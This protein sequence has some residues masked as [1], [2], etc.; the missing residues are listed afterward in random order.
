[1]TN[2][3]TGAHRAPDATPGEGASFP[4]TDLLLCCHVCR[5]EFRAPKKLIGKRLP[6][7]HC[8]ALVDVT[9]G[10]GAAA[11]PLAGKKIGNCRLTYRLGAGGI[12]LVYAADQLSV[13]RRVAI[14]MLGAKAG[15]NQVL[16]SRFQRESQL[17]AQI[18]HPNVVHV[19]DCGFD[20]GVHFQIM[21]LV[22]GGTLAGLIEERGRLPWREACDLALQLS[23]AL[24]LMHR[25]DI[26]HRDIKP[27]NILIGKDAQGRRIAKLA[28]LGLAKQID[29]ASAGNGLTMEGKPLGSPSF[30]PPEQVE[31]AKHATRRSDIYGL[32]ASL[33]MSVTGSRPFEGKTPY[34]VMSRVLTATL[35]PPIS[36]VADLPQPLNELIMRLL[37][38][39]PDGRPESMGDLSKLLE[40]ILTQHA[41]GVPPRA[42]G[43]AGWKRSAPPSAVAAPSADERT[44]PTLQ[45]AT[46][47]R[48]RPA[49]AS[50]W[51]RPG[52]AAQPPAP[53]VASAQLPADARSASSAPPRPEARSWPVAAV[54]V[55]AV[56]IVCMLILVL[57]R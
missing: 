47:P 21:E 11:D 53:A 27:A 7:A 23:Q 33:Y 39:D 13:G 48:T 12:G 41:D 51:K 28:D 29:G 17:A 49:T 24:E 5:H 31:D 37:S 43:T 36:L 8:G 56:V 9:S 22:D 52:S 34:E 25:M 1:M 32:G 26:I 57:I 20:R 3:P 40:A 4:A 30:M 50:T 55:M 14:K 45:P 2:I 42:N 19:Y 38:R 46:G 44:P 15:A 16:V 35:A 18:N 10:A 6:C 54:I